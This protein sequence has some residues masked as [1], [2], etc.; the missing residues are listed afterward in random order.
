MVWNTSASVAE[1]D[2]A[3]RSLAVRE[4]AR[5]EKRYLKSALEHL[6]VS[7][8][9]VRKA[10]GRFAAR[11]PEVGRP[12]LRELVRALWRTGIYEH[13]AAAVELLELREPLLEAAD[14]ELLEELLRASGTWALVDNL[15]ASVVGPL[16]ER[17]PAL[18][19]RL[20]DWAEDPDFWVR[21]AALLAHLLPLRRGEGDFA[22]FSAHA[23]PMLSEREFF[24]RKAIGWVLRETGK[25]RPR[26]VFDWLL[27]RASRAAGLTL[28][29][30]VRHLPAK[31]R[32]ALFA[33]RREA[34]KTM[35]Q[36]S[37]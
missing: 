37:Q 12:E 16:L 14:F 27:P 29:E 36:G 31:D 5:Q 18:A 19:P 20:D 24:I 21:R 3:L 7:V 22:R 11:R 30:A 17:V 10:V 32:E 33:A 2:A 26:L 13:R 23:D 9:G 28:R 15:A 1:L 8:P 35:R 4:R 25:K 6:G 34:P